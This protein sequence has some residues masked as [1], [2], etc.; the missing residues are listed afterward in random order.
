MLP[1]C[2]LLARLRWGGGW[3]TENNRLCRAPGLARAPLLILN[4]LL[5]HK[6][7]RVLGFGEHLRRLRGVLFGGGI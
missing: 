2:Q 3:R 6:V 5:G 4:F 7:T 1:C